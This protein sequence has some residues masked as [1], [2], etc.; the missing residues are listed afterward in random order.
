MSTVNTHIE[1]L[2]NQFGLIQIQIRNQD[3]H[4]RE[5][6]LIDNENI[7]R[8]LAITKFYTK[9]AQD[10]SFH[11]DII[12][13]NAI[14]IV[15]KSHNVSYTKLTL[16]YFKLN[17]PCSLKAEFCDITDTTMGQYSK[18]L[19]NCQGDEILYAEICEIYHP[20]FYKETKSIIPHCDVSLY[21][22]LLKKLN[23]ENQL[24][25]S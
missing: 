19:I 8:T 24:K 11:K 2:Q 7:L 25:N 6:S 3:E 20:K 22:S 23:L 18:L 15:L 1:E 16:A 10:F 12:K 4:Y 9:T 17:V 13:G 14:S 21:K 5:V